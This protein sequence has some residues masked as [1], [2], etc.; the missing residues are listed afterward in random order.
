MYFSVLF[1]IP[2]ENKQE[3]TN[4]SEECGRNIATLLTVDNPYRGLKE[5]DLRILR[6]VT[7]ISLRAHRLQHIVTCA[8]LLKALKE[9]ALKSLDIHVLND[10]HVIYLLKVRLD[11]ISII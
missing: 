4:S 9:G 3:A 2:T 8:P 11:I 6:A 7:E 10:K 5:D 1:V